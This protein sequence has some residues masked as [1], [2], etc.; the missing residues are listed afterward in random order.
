M[1]GDSKGEAMVSDSPKTSARKA[2]ERINSNTSSIVVSERIVN[3]PVKK[4][5]L[6]RR[7]AIFVFPL[8]TQSK[9]TEITVH[10]PRLVVRKVSTDNATIQGKI[11]QGDKLNINKSKPS[12]CIV[13]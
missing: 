1:E 2:Y 6:K 11:N 7:K 8:P 4:T 12:K 5:I 13:Q 10:E 9:T 3:V